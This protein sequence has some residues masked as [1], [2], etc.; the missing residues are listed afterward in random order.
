MNG[1]YLHNSMGSSVYTVILTVDRNPN[2]LHITR[3]GLDAQNITYD[4]SQGS[5]SLNNLAGVDRYKHR[6]VQ[7]PESAEE[8]YADKGVRYKS[9]TNYINALTMPNAR[10]SAEDYR[11]VLEDD[12]AICS[13]FLRHLNT[14]LRAVKAR[15]GNKNTVLSLYTPYKPLNM[16]IELRF[17]NAS[18]FYGTQAMIYS[19]DVRVRF[20]DYI[21]KNLAA[22]PYDLLLGDF[23]NENRIEICWAS[24]SLVQHIGKVTTG[25]GHHHQ[26]PNF[27]DD[28]F[29]GR[30]M[31]N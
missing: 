24:M 20:A 4:I 31:R 22:K 17:G 9:Q 25:L 21:R 10:S 13:N 6:V 23:C 18:Q 30:N 3:Q 26:T 12:I 15:H 5:L 1:N 2:Y 28:M 29:R 7:V 11:L 16:N 27:M 14:Y 8:G 19:D